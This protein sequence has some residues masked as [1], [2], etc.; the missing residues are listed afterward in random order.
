ME[1][2]GYS[3]A[4]SNLEAG[5]IGIAAQCVGMAQAAL[6]IAVDYAKDR[7]SFGQP[8]YRASGGG[9]SALQTLPR[10]WKRHGS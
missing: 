4:L 2:R 6:E 7:R 8:D 10:G 5:R 1:G 3:I 9:G